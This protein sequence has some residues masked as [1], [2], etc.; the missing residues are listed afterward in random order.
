M[1][2]VSKQVDMIECLKQQ[3]YNLKDQLVGLETYSRRS[4]LIFDGIPEF[5]GENP[6]RQVKTLIIKDK[7]ENRPRKHQNRE[8]L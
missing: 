7:L 3:N 8:V 6:W 5:T 4:N 2:A 1:A